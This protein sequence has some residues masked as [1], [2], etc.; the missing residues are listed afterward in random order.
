MSQVVSVGLHTG[1]YVFL[2]KEG[3]KID[4]NV[5]TTVISGD[6]ADVLMERIVQGYQQVPFGQYILRLDEIE[7]V[8]RYEF[9]EMVTFDIDDDGYPLPVHTRLISKNE[10]EQS[11]DHMDVLSRVAFIDPEANVINWLVNPLLGN[12]TGVNPL[13]APVVNELNDD[14]WQILNASTRK[15]LRG[16]LPSVHAVFVRH[17][18]E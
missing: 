13:D 17:Y 7:G 8:N 5:D 1:E 14:N 9:T 11:N 16:K 18:K 6:D 15:Y 4:P 10:Y 12:P 2:N 3:R